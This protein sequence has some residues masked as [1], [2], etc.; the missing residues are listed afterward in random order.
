MGFIKRVRQGEVYPWG[1]RPYRSDYS[2]YNVFY[3]AMLCAPFGF[4]WILK[5]LWAVYAWTFK[6]R[7]SWLDRRDDQVRQ[8]EFDRI[9]GYFRKRTGLGIIEGVSVMSRLQGKLGVKEE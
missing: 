7:Q 1:Y 8:A 2:D 4:H 6:Y 9:D 3:R 5:A